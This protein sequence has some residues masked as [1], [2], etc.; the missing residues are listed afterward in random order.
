MVLLS[1]PLCGWCLVLSHVYMISGNLAVGSR[2]RIHL[3]QGSYVLRDSAHAVASVRPDG[4]DRQCW[5]CSSLD[6][7]AEHVQASAQLLKFQAG[8]LNCI[9]G[10]WQVCVDH[11]QTGGH[12]QVIQCAS[13]CLCAQKT[14]RRHARYVAQEGC[15]CTSEA[16][17]SSSHASSIP[18]AAISHARAARSV[19]CRR[20]ESEADCLSKGYV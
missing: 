2:L 5:H 13:I 8:P 10:C 12:A 16:F 14:L 4:P 3:S 1:S 17:S 7:A 6:G 19:L 11:L 15:Q 9:E 18:C 20:T